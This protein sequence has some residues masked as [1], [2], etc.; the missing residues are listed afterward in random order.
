MQEK[1]KVGQ[2]S[3]LLEK[4][5]ESATLAMARMSRELASQGK[6]VVNLSLGE[7]DFNTPDFIKDAAKKAIDENVT[8]YPPVNG[9][10]EVRKAVS[11][12]FKRDNGLNYSPEEIVISTGAKQSLANAILALVN[13]GDEVIMPS[14]YWVSYSELVKIA[15]GTTVEV[16]AGIDSDFKITPEALRKAIT[17]NTKLVIY[18]S[19]CN[20]TGS[21]YSQEEL[22]ALADVILEHEGIYVISDEIY[23]HINFVGKSS[24]IGTCA[25]MLE[26]T[27]TVNGVSKAFAMT[28]WRLGYIGAP[29][30]IAQACSKMQGQITSGA[31]TISQMAAKAALEADPAVIAEMIQVFKSRRDRVYA[32]L[33]TIPGLKVNL[34]EAAF[35]F[36]MDVTAFFNTTDGETVVR[37]SD[38]LAMYLL[39]KVYLATVGG[40]AFGDAN[41]IRI[42]YA[43]SEEMLDEAVK[44][45]REGLSHLK[46]V[47]A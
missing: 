30:W 47:T 5:S 42:S 21:V 9:F 6:P 3:E 43:T 8:H 33:I 13:Q 20:P 39:K 36:Y 7:P 45:L 19:P 31:C 26:R 25:G 40:E 17:P 41:C 27:V 37:T 24:S 1:S 34:P 46:P 16:Y 12:K 2:V 10:L 32:G 44:R 11:E 14:P 28:G 38:D 35:Y 22:Q 23:E 29:L 15:G 18:S 4:L